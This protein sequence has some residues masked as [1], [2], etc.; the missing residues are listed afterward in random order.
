MQKQEKSLKNYKIIKNE[1]S[2]NSLIASDYAGAYIDDDGNLVV[3]IADGC[4]HLQAK[5]AY[6][7]SNH[8][9]SSTV[10]TI[11]SAVDDSSVTYNSFCVAVKAGYIIAKFN[12]KLCT[13]SII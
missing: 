13:E 8:A 6:I 2:S 11:S 4:D 12:L 10:Q 9:L 7:A 1:L 3:M 5:N